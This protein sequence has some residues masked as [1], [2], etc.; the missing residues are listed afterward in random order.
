MQ[1]IITGRHFEVTD[2]IRSYV[3][4]KIVKLNRFAP[5]IL[6]VHI[7]LSV[8]KYRHIAEITL[9]AKHYKIST[10]VQ[11]ANMY[12]AIDGVVDKVA[13]RIKRHTERLSKHKVKLG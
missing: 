1:I 7:F 5:K 11:T 12:S 2:A 4:R 9:L 3:E 10:R 13:T 8:E 6:E